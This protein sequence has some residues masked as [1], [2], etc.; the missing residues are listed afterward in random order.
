[1]SKRERIEGIITPSI[2][3]SQGNVLEIHIALEDEVNIP[4]KPNHKSSELSNYTGAVVVLLGWMAASGF[5]VEKYQILRFH[6]EV[7][8]EKH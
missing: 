7:K 8:H 3:D 2:W 5:V 1:M 6:Q 4:L